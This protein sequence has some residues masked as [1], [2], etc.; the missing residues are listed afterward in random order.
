VN[1]S[2]LFSK[3]TGRCSYPTLLNFISTAT[4]IQTTNQ[5]SLIET[6]QNT[7]LVMGGSYIVLACA[8]GY[9]NNGGNLNISCSANNSWTQFPNCILNTAN[10]SMTNAT[11]S[12]GNGS[13]CI[14]DQ[15]T[16]F[17]ITNGYYSSSILAYASNTTASGNY[18]KSS[19]A[20][21]YPIYSRID[22]IYMRAWLCT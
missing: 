6:T 12:T 8:N 20:F 2:R 7:S 4:G 18:I 22:S 17:N 1:L 19:F 9:I 11:I 15:A 16:T 14:I 3:V 21:Y 5:S 10:G 13:P